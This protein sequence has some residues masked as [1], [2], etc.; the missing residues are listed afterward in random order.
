MTSDV[1]ESIDAAKGLLKNNPGKLCEHG[2][3]NPVYQWT[4]ESVFN[5]LDYAVAYNRTNA[6]AVLASG[7]QVFSMLN[8]GINNID[9]FDINCLTEYYALG[10]KRAM[11]LSYF[12]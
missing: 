4:N 9:T 3:F 5:A 6:L 8:F 11:I 10:F 12:Y 7:D 1:R 2:T